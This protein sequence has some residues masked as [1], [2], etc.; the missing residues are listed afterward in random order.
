MLGNRFWVNVR[1]YI[2]L[3]FPSTFHIRSTKGSSS[4]ILKKIRWSSDTY[5]SLLIF[6]PGKKKTIHT[7]GLDLVTGI[8]NPCS[9]VEFVDGFIRVV[10][11]TVNL[12]QESFDVFILF[13]CC[14]FGTTLVSSFSLSRVRRRKTRH[15]NW[16]PLRHVRY[17]W[18]YSTET[19]VKLSTSTD[20]RTRQLSWTLNKKKID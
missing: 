7:L 8:W 6:N 15:T 11:K 3:M 10:F 4:L 16:R 19:L 20:D 5:H 1:M 12:T 13:C 9:R 18:D 2:N 17:T 14:H